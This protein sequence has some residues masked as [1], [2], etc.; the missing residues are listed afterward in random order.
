MNAKID[1]AI[2]VLAEKITDEVRADDALK[3]TQAASNLANTKRCLIDS[4]V[5][6]AVSEEVGNGE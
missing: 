4:A 2:E 6:L 1:K 3:Y 5:V